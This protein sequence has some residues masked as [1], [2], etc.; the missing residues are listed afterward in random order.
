MARQRE[1]RLSHTI[2]VKLRAEYGRHLYVFKVHGGPLMPAGLPDII[3]VV[4]GRF[5]ALETKIPDNG[6]KPTEIQLYV[7]TRVRRAGGIV[8]VPRSVA[9]ALDIVREGLTR[10]TSSNDA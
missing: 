1:S 10:G 4:H 9:D 3:G 7:M 8:G 6:N 2:M 5:F